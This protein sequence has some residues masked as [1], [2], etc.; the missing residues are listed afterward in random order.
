MKY[1]DLLALPYQSNGRVGKDRGTD[2]YGY[3][4]ELCRRNSKPLK[5]F[6]FPSEKVPASSLNEY[7]EKINL[8]T[9]SEEEACFGDLVQ[10]EFEGNLHIAFL[11]D[12]TTVT[13]MT[14]SGARVSPVTALQKRKYMRII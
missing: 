11:L 1:D 3:V 13:H 4:L 12:K 5:D 6:V 14:F 9:I 10:C 8:K 2:C 7:Y